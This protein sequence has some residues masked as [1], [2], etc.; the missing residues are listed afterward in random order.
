MGSANHPNRDQG[1]HL[2]ILQAM[3]KVLNSVLD[4]STL[5]NELMELDRQVTGVEACSLMLL[6][7]A[8]QELVFE[9]AHG[10]KG[11]M[12]RQHRLPLDLGVCGWVAAHGQP[13]VINDVTKDPRFNPRVDEQTGFTTRSI[14]AVPLWSEGQ[15]IGVIEVLN[16][17]S[18]EPFDDEDLQVVTVLAT[19]ASAAIESARAYQSLQRERDHI[20]RTEESLRRELVAE[21]RSGPLQ[22]LAA[23]EMNV[24]FAEKLIGLSPERARTELQKLRAMVRS[25]TD[26]VRNILF[27]LRPL[28]LETH[29]LVAA[30]Q[31]FARQV[32]E[33]RPAPVL[34]VECLVGRLSA[35]KEQVAFTVSR[36]AVL[37]AL[38]H[39]HAT[40]IW[41]DLSEK[42]GQLVV[43]VRDNGVGFDPQAVLGTGDRR[44]AFG[45]FQMRERAAH[46]GGSTSVDSAVG[47][48]TTVTLTIP[49]D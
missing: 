8:R 4:L 18:G 30:L 7:P 35:E 5:L 17:V 27:D 49:M 39:A 2:Q 43:T 29:G 31:S 25:T 10:E 46:V 45:V 33:E 32:S 47:R 3:G 15:V 40:H 22:K 42:D 37:N 19:Q 16:K 6:D 11:Q 28:V 44:A 1:N 36:E 26:E 41:V 48:G 23:A 14:L 34:T 12:L 21:L 24:E 13:A 9:V 38:E 20:I